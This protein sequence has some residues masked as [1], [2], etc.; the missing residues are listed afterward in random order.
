MESF[1]AKKRTSAEEVA[2]GIF[3]MMGRK[4]LERMVGN[5]L[6]L[7]WWQQQVC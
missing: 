6:F 4:S 7:P 3:A 2:M 5:N 1:S